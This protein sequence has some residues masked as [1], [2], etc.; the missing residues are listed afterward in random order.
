MPQG[1]WCEERSL[2]LPFCFIA[3]LAVMEN[4]WHWK[5]GTVYPDVSTASNVVALSP[6]T[7]FDAASVAFR[8]LERFTVVLFQE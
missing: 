6:F 7:H 2:A 1:I 8:C 5:H 3:L 4:V